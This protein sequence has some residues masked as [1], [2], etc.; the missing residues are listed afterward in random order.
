MSVLCM[1][2]QIYVVYDGSGA[3]L[4]FL[5]PEICSIFASR[6]TFSG[7]HLLALLGIK[8]PWTKIKSRCKEIFPCHISLCVSMLSCTNRSFAYTWHFADL[9]NLRVEWRYYAVMMIWS[10]RNLCCIL[11]SSLQSQPQVNLQLWIQCDKL[12]C[13]SEYMSGCWNLMSDILNLEYRR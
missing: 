13:N 3:F 6:F 10:V 5:L 4:R 12:N 11:N 9:E 7:S 2:N 8:A 1:E